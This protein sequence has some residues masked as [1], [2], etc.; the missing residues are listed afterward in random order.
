MIALLF[1]APLVGLRAQTLEALCS[2][3]AACI[4]SGELLSP[5][6]GLPDSTAGEAALEANLR[7]IEEIYLTSMPTEKAEAAVNSQLQEPIIRLR[8][9]WAIATPQLREAFDQG[10]LPTSGPN[11]P[12]RAFKKLVNNIT[13]NTGVMVEP[14]KEFFG[15]ANVYGRAYGALPGVTNPD[16]RPFQ[17]SEAI[18]GNPWTTDQTSAIAVDIQQSETPPA[19]YANQSWQGLSD[20]PAFPSGH[21][22]GGNAAGLISAMAAPQYYKELVSAGARFALSRNIFGAHYPLDV[23]GGRIVAFYNVA[24]TLNGTFDYPNT[25]TLEEVTQAGAELRAYLGSG[26]DSPYAA[27]CSA[28]VGACIRDG[29]IPSPE[30]FEKEREDYRFLLTYGLPPV[31]PTELAPVV[32]EGAEILLATRFPYLSK[33]QLRTV[34]ATT[35]IPSGAALDDGSGWARLDL[36]SAA[37]GYGAFG[38]D[39][40]VEM[41]A[42]KG[43]FHAFDV[44]T[45]NIEGD[46]GLTKQGGGTL[47]LAGDNS[48]AGGTRIEAGTLAVSGGIEGAVTVA[49]GAFFYNG[50]RV[51]AIGDSAVVSAGRLV[52]DG[53]IASDLSNSGELHNSGVITGEVVNSGRLSGNGRIAGSLASSG[54]VAPGNSIGRIEVTGPV[55][56]EAGSTYEVEIAADGRSD[57]LAAGGPV[58]LSGGHLAVSLDNASSIGLQSFSI[59]TSESGITGGFG[60]VTDPFGSAFPFLDLEVSSGGGVVVLASVRSDVPFAAFAETPNQAAVAKALDSLPSEGALIDALVSLN[61]ASAP[62]AYETLSGEV[63]G[64]AQTVLQTQSIY[65]RDAVGGR[66]RQVGTPMAETSGPETA[67]LLPGLS[68]TLWLQGYGS[69][70][71]TDATGDTAQLSRSIGG[72]V[73][74]LDVAVNETLQVGL[75]A[76]FGRSDFDVDALSSSGS[77]DT[78]DLAVYAGAELGPVGL[79]GGAA[80]GWHRVSVDRSVVLAD[81]SDALSSDYDARTV[82]VFGEVGYGIESEGLFLEP[83]AGIAYVNLK[84]DGFTE[85][86]GEAALSGAGDTQGNAFSTLGL[87]AAAA[88][89]VG[90]G[91]LVAEGSLAWQRS[92]G[93]VTPSADLAFAAGGAGF[94][95]SGAPLARDSALVGATLGY[96]AADNVTVGLSYA[97]QLAGS[98]R[99]NAVTGRVSV[100]F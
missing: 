91:R 59:L 48:Y 70:G 67:S 16:P 31:G 24:N 10:A 53:S 25:I 90:Q 94:S 17:V 55:V 28:D 44:W 35:Q 37:D 22:T 45:N 65:L 41:E 51:T 29:A 3:E 26:G 95:V 30:T 68:P 98:A 78:Y 93:D 72:F 32:P 58:T 7:R 77:S 50:G 18:A 9:V 76:G 86:G 40:T 42:A 15:E 39:V 80:Y 4:A 83:F 54:T 1:L 13:H 87:R 64:S 27:A 5:F 99:D 19:P 12:P 82:Q 33:E 96:L 71:S 81:Y 11:G 75:A 92:F 52:N 36:F 61:E 69:W 14:L 49:E 38:A 85:S 6:L 8:N 20:S 2:N 57:S 66:L 56:F 63:Y 79:R 23:I 34:L 60:S 46:G 100:A 97:G 89:P 73:A 47:V 43:G 84:T 88:L 74:G 62:G 21:S